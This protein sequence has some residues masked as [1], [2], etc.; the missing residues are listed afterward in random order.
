M[1]RHTKAA[2]LALL[3]VAAL[4]LRSVSASPVKPSPAAGATSDTSSSAPRVEELREQVRK[5]ETAFAKTMADRDHKA[6]A[7]FLADEAIFVGTR[8]TFRGKRAVAEGWKPLY[9]GPKAAFSWAPEKV[10][11]VDSGTLALSSGPVFDP[12]GKRVGTFNSTWRREGDGTWKIVLDNGCPDC[13]CG[14]VK[15]EKK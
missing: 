4:S 13:D 6:F 12:S 14:D 10:E 2:T 11:V 8:R 5:V 15:A 1:I 7:S 9:D 3:A